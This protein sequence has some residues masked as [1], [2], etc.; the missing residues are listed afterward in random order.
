MIKRDL[1]IGLG[2]MMLGLLGLTVLIPNWIVVP[3]SIDTLALSPAFWPRIVMGMLMVTGLAVTAQALLAMRKPTQTAERDNTRSITHWGKLL[4]A[5]ALMFTYYH[6]IG[7]LGILLS[8]ILV[9]I[10]LMLLG[11]ERRYWLVGL[12]SVL[13]PTLLYY[14]FRDIANVVLPDGIFY[15]YNS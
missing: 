10:G 1:L 9:L 15:R 6:L 8:S 14:F 12:V 4:C 13:L 7:W 2:T 11:N 3:Q 5:I